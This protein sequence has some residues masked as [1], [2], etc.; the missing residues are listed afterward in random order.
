MAGT[1]GSDTINETEPA[2]TTAGVVM[3]CDLPMEA[4]ADCCQQEASR[5]LAKRRRV[6][7]CD[8]CNRLVLSYGDRAD[9]ERTIAE[10]TDN[11]VEFEVGSSGKLLIIAYQR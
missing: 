2:A 5:S 4:L 6:A 9:Y 10:L 8:G 7:R 3:E 1:H 11:G